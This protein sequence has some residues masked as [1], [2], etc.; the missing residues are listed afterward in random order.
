MNAKFSPVV[1]EQKGDVVAVCPLTRIGDS[2]H[3][4]SDAFQV[5]SHFAQPASSIGPIVNE[6]VAFTAQGP[7]QEQKVFIG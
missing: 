3:I 7:V 1:G 5:P 6:T 2:S 4:L